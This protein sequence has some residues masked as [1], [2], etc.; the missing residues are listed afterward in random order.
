[1]HG[2]DPF[3]VATLC[4]TFLVDNWAEHSVVFTL[5][6]LSRL[7]TFVMLCWALRPNQLLRMHGE[8]LGEGS[9]RNF[10]MEAWRSIDIF[11]FRR[12]KKR[13]GPELTGGAYTIPTH[14]TA[15][16]RVANEGD[17]DEDS[18]GDERSPL[19]QS[20]EPLSHFRDRIVMK[21]T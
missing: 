12:R 10:G 6:S 15:S 9:M 1:M 3:E 13:W 11:G 19:L 14:D 18:E 17:S 20:N 7:T 4:T 16:S 8:R 5:S 21:E 2:A